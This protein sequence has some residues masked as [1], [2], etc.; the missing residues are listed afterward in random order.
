MIAQ[1]IADEVARLLAEGRL[2]Q[3]QIARATGISRGTVGSIAQGKRPR[4]RPVESFLDPTRPLGPPQRCRGCGGY[5][6][7]PCLLCRVRALKDNEL[8][9]S[10]TA[11][12]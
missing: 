2:S 5:V 1:A 6:Y 4:R 12:A 9:A 7:L 8:A 10:R 11:L 3:R